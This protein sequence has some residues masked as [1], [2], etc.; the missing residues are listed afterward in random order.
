MELK[1]VHVSRCYISFILGI[2]KIRLSPK[3]IIDIFIFALFIS[4]YLL[5]YQCW[6]KFLFLFSEIIFHFSDFQTQFLLH[7]SY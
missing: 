3:Y 7:Y 6:K 5:F 4:N 1:P 2:G